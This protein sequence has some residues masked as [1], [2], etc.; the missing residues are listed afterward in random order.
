MKT[1]TFLVTEADEETAVLRDVD[2]GQVHALAENPGVEAGEVVD[3]TVEA[4]P[5]LE[6]AWRVVELED[7]RTVTVEES[8]EPPT[9]QEQ[10]LAADQPVGGVT[11]QERA[12]DG[13]LHVLTV[14]ED[15]TEQAVADVRD[16][17]AI[18]ERAARLGVERVEIRS[19]AGVV[20]VRY[21][22]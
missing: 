13:E 12:G 1:G 15:D 9:R 19:R 2:G 4:E 22:P 8:P 3:A 21:L 10:Q 5:P 20:S 11:R 6:V 18:R 7:R 17:P 16:D 14:P